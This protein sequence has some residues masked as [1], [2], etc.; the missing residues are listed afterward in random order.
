MSIRSMLGVALW[1]AVQASVLLAP[2]LAQERAVGQE[3]AAEDR[4]ASFKAV[5]GAVKED[6]PG[7]PLLVGAYG[8]ILAVIV[9][10]VVRI[11][12]LQQQ[13]QNDLVRLQRQLGVT[14][15]QADASQEGAKR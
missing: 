14:Q 10:Y 8:V 5:E 4:A 15:A 2:V 11:A 3:S 7:G 1:L 12:R 6:V 9:G 13:A